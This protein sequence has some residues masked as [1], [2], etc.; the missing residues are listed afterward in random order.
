MLQLQ[1]KVMTHREEEVESL[2]RLRVMFVLMSSGPESKDKS[3]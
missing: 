3:A 1:E 2:I